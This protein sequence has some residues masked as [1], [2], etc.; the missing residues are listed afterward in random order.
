M[1]GICGFAAPASSLNQDAIAIL[2]RMNGTMLHRGPDEEGVYLDSKVGLGSR[3]LSII[4]LAGGQ[5]PIPNEDKTLW[6]VLN[7]EI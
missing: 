3:R 4:D 2:H 6:I 7:G 5:Q 1:C